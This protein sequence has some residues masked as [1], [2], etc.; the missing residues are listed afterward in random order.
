MRRLAP[1]LALVALLAGV[2]AAYGAPV[3]A[4]ELLGDLR[5]AAPKGDG[6]DRDLFDHWVDEDG[7]GC[8]ARDEVLL[9]EARIPPGVTG[10][11]SL[12]GGRWWSAYDDL[13]VS[14]ARRLDIDHFVPLAEAWR[15][16]ARR[17]D[18]DTRRRFANDLDYP[19]TLIAV[20]AST[21]RSKSDQ[22][23]ATW[24]PSF[25]AYRCTY[26]ASWI[27]VKWRWRL[28]VDAL[29]R[30]AL[31]V[32]L[33]GC[34]RRALVPEPTRARIGL[35]G[36]EEEAAS[37][38]TGGGASTGTADGAPA[39]GPGDDPRFG[40]C[41]EALAAGYGPYVLGR[42]PEYAWYRDGDRDGTVCE[43]APAA[44]APAA[45]VAGDDPR[46]GSCR[47]AKA[48]GYGPYVEGRDPEY[49][50]YRDG[51]GDGTVCE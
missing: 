26:V 51:D 22:D 2:P 30:G 20:T 17:W 44:A 37:S 14:S 33:S 18:A 1:L 5:S 31:T 4:R 19:L 32:G 11:C 36:A 29:E 28:T 27:A 41:R 16:G 35:G 42:D 25:G 8:D 9:A 34:G 7:D 15:S 3:S 21:N 38:S 24:L 43:G 49:A 40:S 13:L 46:F 39:T 6:Y 12:V 50:W 45:P 10:R 48:A 23:P 47:E